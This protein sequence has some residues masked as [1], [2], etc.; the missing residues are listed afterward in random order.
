MATLHLMVGLPCSGKT[1]FAR[2]L[3]KRYSALRLSPDEWHT[4]LGHEYGY[5]MTEL[6]EEIHNARHDAVES[7]MWDVAA[8]VLALGVDAILDFGFWGR[9]ERDQF[10]SRAK[11]LGADF[12]IHFMDIS[13]EVLFERL[14]SRNAQKPDATFVIPEAKLKEWMKIFEKPSPDELEY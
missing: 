4:R 6:D 5:K 7:L 12:R 13:E 9:C 8:R 10:R 11:E 14:R 2:E 3:E 1:T